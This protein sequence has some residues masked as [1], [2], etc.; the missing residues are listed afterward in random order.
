MKLKI[1]I[2]IRDILIEPIKRNFSLKYSCAKI[3]KK[4]S[5]EKIIIRKSTLK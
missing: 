5:I 3:I 2:H 1:K 4:F